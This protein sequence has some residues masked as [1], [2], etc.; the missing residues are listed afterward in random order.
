MINRF[1]TSDIKQVKKGLE[2]AKA[3]QMAEWHINLAY[4]HW[5]R[6]FKIHSHSS[7]QWNKK[8]L[9]NLN[10]PELADS[11][12]WAPVLSVLVSG[13]L[14]S[15]SPNPKSQGLGK[16]KVSSLKALDFG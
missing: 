5:I 13:Q 4:R 1:L 11:S 8:A 10:H 9:T 7:L 6:T 12:S 2:V 16:S 15:L 3:E 14:S